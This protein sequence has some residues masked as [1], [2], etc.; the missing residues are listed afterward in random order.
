MK[1]NIND[2]DKKL[3]LALIGS[4][5]KLITHPSDEEVLF[6]SLRVGD[7]EDTA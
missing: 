2:R 4:D 7:E 3:S 6:Q 1:L 5:L